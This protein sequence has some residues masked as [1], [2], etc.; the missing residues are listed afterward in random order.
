[1]TIGEVY[2]DT[3][4]AMRFLQLFPTG[5]EVPLEITW[6]SREEYSIK[7]EQL[8][9][10]RNGERTEKR[11]RDDEESY[12]DDDRD[13]TAFIHV[14]LRTSG[15]MSVETGLQLLYVISGAQR[16]WVFHALF[17]NLNYRRGGSS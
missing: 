11:K 12:G 3:E 8:V 9:G 2:D 4:R 10:E 15:R 17:R 14:V 7:P 6:E 16:N 5:R 1:M 13:T